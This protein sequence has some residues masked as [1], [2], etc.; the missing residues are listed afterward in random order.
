VDPQ[1]WQARYADKIGA[2][3][4]QAVQ[5]GRAGFMLVFLSEFPSSSGAPASGWGGRY[6][7]VSALA[8]LLLSPPL[9]SRV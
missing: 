1:D 5:E 8:G 2:N 7:V 4:C 9:A 6:D 3:T